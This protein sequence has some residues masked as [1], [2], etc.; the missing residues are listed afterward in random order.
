MDYQKTSINHVMMHNRHLRAHML[1]A[2]RSG[3]RRRGAC[4]RTA[5]HSPVLTRGPARRNGSLL[6]SS[7][8]R[9]LPD[10]AAA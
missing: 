4:L 8:G 5:R 1:A 6:R 7:R 3:L 9:S 2:L 10:A